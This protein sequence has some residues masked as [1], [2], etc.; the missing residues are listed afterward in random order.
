MTSSVETQVRVIL[1]EVIDPCSRVAGSPAGLDDMGLV[2]Q[3]DVTEADNT[4]RV[5]VVIGITEFGCMMGGAFLHEASEKLG[6]VFGYD[7]VVVELGDSYDWTPEDMSKTYK[8]RLA[9]RRA[10]PQRSYRVE[11][12]SASIGSGRRRE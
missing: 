5:H 9:A 11:S 7:N 1:N 8:I 3:I 2:R 4:T 10:E 6:S 12:R